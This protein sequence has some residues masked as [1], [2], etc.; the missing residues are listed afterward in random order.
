MEAASIPAAATG[1]V[2]II[3]NDINDMPLTP[4]MAEAIS[5][6]TE[7]DNFNKQIGRVEV[8]DDDT[9]PVPPAALQDSF[10]DEADDDISGAAKNSNKQIRKVKISNENEGPTHPMEYE[11]TYDDED[12]IAKKKAREDI[13]NNQ[14]TAEPDDLES[15]YDVP[16][17]ERDA[18]VR[19]VI[20]TGDGTNNRRGLEDFEARARTDNNNNNTVRDDEEEGGIV[21]DNEVSDEDE[22]DNEDVPLGDRSTVHIPEAFLV[23]DISVYDERTLYDAT[24][25]L[26]WW[27]QRRT[28]VLLGVMFVI[29]AALV[30]TLGVTLSSS[31]P[32]RIVTADST[33]SPTV[34]M[35]PTSSPTTCVHKITENAQVIDL[36]KDL[37]IDSPYEPKVAVDGRNMVV[38]SNND[39]DWDYEGLLFIMFYSLDDDETWQRIQTIR[40]ENMG[41]WY[42][43]ALSGT[44]AFVG[45]EEANNDQGI[46]LVYEQNQFG[47]W[48]K[49]ENPFVHDDNVTRSG[50][51]WRVEI[52]GDLACVKDGNNNNL[53]HR[54]GNNKW[55]QFDT[56]DD[57]NE[58]AISGDI[59]AIYDWVSDFIQLYQYNQDTKNMTPI[60]APISSTGY[61]E[62]M[63][64]SNDYLVYWDTDEYDTVIY[65]QD[66]KNQTLTFHQQLNIT[67]PYDNSLTLDNN[68]LVVGGTNHTHIF[69]LQNDEWVETITLDQAFNDYQ[70][71]G[72][73]LIAISEDNEVYS[74]N[75]Q[76]CMQAMPTQTPSISVAPSL[77]L[78]SHPSTRLSSP[79]SLVPS[80]SVSPS[81][82]PTSPPS[83]VPSSSVS[84]TSYWSTLQ[85]RQ[86]GIA[87]AGD[88]ADDVA[89]RSVAISGDGSTLVV[90][91]PRKYGNGLSAL[92]T[93]DRPGYV[94]VYYKQFDL[95]GWKW[96]LVET[97]TGKEVG[98]LFGTSVSMSEDGKTLAIGAPGDWN[99]QDMP[100][101]T[102]V[103]TR[104]NDKWVQLG[105][106]IEGEALGDRSGGRCLYHLMVNSLL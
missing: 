87:I 101:Y 81:M 35:F 91:A 27:K 15:V 68:V 48:E 2:E 78:S 106:D 58:C 77:A 59:I 64:L 82:Y 16:D 84:P 10:D 74:F 53:Y 34:S 39:D 41:Y 17:I 50:F 71:S 21:N 19:G 80:S 12:V 36:Q 79:P 97:F 90:G 88:S 40:L 75:I 69:S 7:P 99:D 32:K 13:N 65:S 100:G 9:A 62:S 96:K 54:E 30:I 6:A 14:R 63:D 56:V 26:P 31:P 43:V 105:E 86:Q 76:D 22:G 92:G 73:T 45:F 37:Q 60:L 28:R 93:Y 49:A 55:V 38:V 25:I 18:I 20:N 3:D 61:I 47:E 51:E 83:L 44:T 24:P 23:D 72:R 29:V 98:D 52:D 4:G 11:D 46:V 8:M 42:E 94:K 70:L 89:G 33:P 104:K 102:R 66:D 85:W 103:Y 1:R 95:S 5:H 57:G 67:G